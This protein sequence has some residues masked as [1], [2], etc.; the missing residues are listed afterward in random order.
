MQE[1]LEKYGAKKCEANAL[2]RYPQEAERI[3]QAMMINLPVNGS[4]AG[5]GGEVIRAT[6]TGQ[7]P[8]DI[9]SQL[10]TALA[11]QSKIIEIDELTKR[12][13]VW[14]QKK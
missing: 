5:Q 4:L 9:G 1:Y 14:E 2:L 8:P 12:I 13:E 6:M 10:I 11:N 7:I 3:L